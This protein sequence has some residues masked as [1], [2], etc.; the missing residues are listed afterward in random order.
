VSGGL[1]DRTAGQLGGRS[2][3]GVGETL[4]HGPEHG[5]GT[6][7]EI[8]VVSKRSSAHD[9]QAISGIHAPNVTNQVD[10]VNRLPVYR[11]ETGLCRAIPGVTVYGYGSTM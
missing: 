6:G 11:G 1:E 5:G 8:E 10:D 7:A 2:T 9:D 3:E 4:V